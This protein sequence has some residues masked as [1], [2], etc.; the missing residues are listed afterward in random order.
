MPLM[1]LSLVTSKVYSVCNVDILGRVYGRSSMCN[2]KLL[3][4][5]TN[6]TNATH[7]GY[8]VHFWSQRQTPYSAEIVGLTRTAGTPKSSLRSTA[9]T[10]PVYPR[11]SGTNSQ[12]TN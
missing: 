6:S 7:Q 11:S 5:H 8:Q 3:L 9:I 2:D 4:I 10:H 12:S 1:P